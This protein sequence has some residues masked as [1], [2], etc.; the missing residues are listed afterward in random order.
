[1]GRHY[2]PKYYL[3][4]FSTPENENVIVTYQIS[5]QNIFTTNLDNIAQENSY[6][7]KSIEKFLSDKIEEP[8]NK[9]LEKIRRF[10][11]I[12]VKDKEVFCDYIVV[13]VKRV[14]YFYDYMNTF[15]PDVI[16]SIK[17]KVKNSFIEKINNNIIDVKEKERIMHEIDIFDHSNLF[18][19]EKKNEIWLE[20]LAPEMTPLIQEII[21][22]KT[23]LFLVS[24][25]PQLFITCDNPIFFHKKLGLS[26]SEITFPI[27][28]NIALYANNSNENNLEYLFPRTQIV[29]EINRRSIANS[30]RFVFS[31]KEEDWILKIIRKQ[32]NIHLN[33]IIL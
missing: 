31:S 32:E 20:F 9:V 4:G 3:K 25:N 24:K 5:S 33:Q 29:K 22:L 14:P 30:K 2:I 18:N 10:E 16:N 17:E 19:D 1:M 7:P 21:K 12:S 8:A 13:L 6:Y 26:E 23:W 28:K 27:S 15:Y 11:K